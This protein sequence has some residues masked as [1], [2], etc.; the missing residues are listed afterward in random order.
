MKRKPAFDVVIDGL[1][2]ANVNKDKTKQSETVR[3]QAQM[4]KQSLSQAP[5][6]R[7]SL[8]R[9]SLHASLHMSVQ[10][11]GF[12]TTY[13]MTNTTVCVCGRCVLK[14]AKYLILLTPLQLVCLH[15]SGC[16]WKL[17]ICIKAMPPPSDVRWLRAQRKVQV[18]RTHFP[19]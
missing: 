13:T 10:P 14:L 17:S 19:R 9:I 8:F 7:Q 1:N 15:L 6:D 3:S 4:Y 18:D 16:V 5:A 2:V 12:F 11:R